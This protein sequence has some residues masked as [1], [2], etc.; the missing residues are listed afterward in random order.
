MAGVLFLLLLLL[1]CAKEPTAGDIEKALAPKYRWFGDI[2]EVRITSLVKL[3]EDTYF[4]QITYGVRFSRDLEEME[5]ELLG[6]L[7]KGTLY[8]DLS[9][10]TLIV[11]L[12]EMVRKCG[13]LNIR[14]GKTCYLSGNVELVNV[15]GSWTVRFR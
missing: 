4:A 5:E 9:L 14:K 2:T 11:S 7:R 1:S 13:R 10:L 8:R 15:R 3:D 6:K 12:N